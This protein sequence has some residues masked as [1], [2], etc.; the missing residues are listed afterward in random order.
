[1]PDITW[2]QWAAK[3]AQR[4]GKVRD[5]IRQATRE[6]VD[7]AHAE[8][9]ALL[10]RLIYSIPEDTSSYSYGTKGGKRGGRYV[11]V[12]TGEGLKT[13]RRK[14]FSHQGTL[15]FESKGTGEK[16]LG[17]KKKWK[18]TGNLR[19]SE[20]KKV[21]SATEGRLFND[22]GYALPRHNLGMSPG[23]PETIPPPPRKKR[24]TTRQAPW[25]SRAVNNTAAARLENYR[26][27]L[28]DALR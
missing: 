11:K 18:R 27:G 26:R 16:A 7:L 23:D 4:P 9:K 8:A 5:A 28:F 10:N 24:N 20:K 21:V 22:A 19:N 17:G 14:V 1:M 2:Q 15:L 3:M 6:N 12:Q 13:G 25:R